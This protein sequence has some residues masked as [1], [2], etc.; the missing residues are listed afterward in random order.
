[1]YTNDLDNSVM[2]ALA[3][4]VE[5]TVLNLDFNPRIGDLCGTDGES[6]E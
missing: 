1:M 5:L 4:L 6:H 3:P 2:E